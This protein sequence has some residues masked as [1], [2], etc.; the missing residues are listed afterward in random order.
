M[1]K[2]KN[3]FWLTWV[4]VSVV[5][6]LRELLLVYLTIA[7]SVSFLH[8]QGNWTR[9]EHAAVTK[10]SATV[11]CG[12][13]LTEKGVRPSTLKSIHFESV[14]FDFYF[15][16]VYRFTAVYYERHFWKVFLLFYPL[17]QI[18]P[19]ITNVMAA[20]NSNQA[21]WKVMRRR[22]KKTKQQLRLPSG[23]TDKGF[24][25]L[26]GSKTGRLTLFYQSWVSVCVTR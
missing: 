24:S 26:E 25:S 12:C 10:K 19:V 20:I 3:V 4:F 7:Q 1:E 16:N 15:H 21:L 13:S 8:A 14:L 6:C 2:K 9:W 5:G 23:R 18:V 11:C 17:N 22:R